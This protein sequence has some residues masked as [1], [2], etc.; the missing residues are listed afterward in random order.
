MVLKKRCSHVTSP[1]ERHYTTDYKKVEQKSDNENLPAKLYHLSP[2]VRRQNLT[3]VTACQ[4]PLSVLY[5]HGFEHIGL[6]SSFNPKSGTRQFNCARYIEKH[7][8]RTPDAFGIVSMVLPTE[9]RIWLLGGFQM[10]PG[11]GQL[12]L[13]RDGERP[14]GGRKF[15]DGRKRLQIAA[16]RQKKLEILGGTANCIELPLDCRHG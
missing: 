8:E 11:C 13:R 5:L 12:A 7:R 9:T 4:I 10:P 14:A 6:N 2:T 1:S 16:L 3:F 15:F